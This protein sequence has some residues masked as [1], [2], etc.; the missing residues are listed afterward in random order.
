[1]KIV[2][3]EIQNSIILEAIKRCPEV[4]AVP[5]NDLDIAAAMLAHGEAD[6]MIAGID[7]TTRDVVVACRD[8]IGT[9]DKFFSSCFVMTRGDEKFIL[10]DGGVCKKP[11]ADMLTSVVL[12][13]YESAL[14]LLED[15]P[16]IAMLSFSTFGSGRD[17]SIDMIHEVINRVRTARPEILIDGE[18][19]LDV[20]INPE[21]AAKK[22]ANSPV[23]G[24][25][26]VL[27]CPDLN[28]GN[29]LYKALERLGGWTA[30]GPIL[31]GFNK[32]ISDLSRGSTVDD[33]VAVIK[34]IERLGA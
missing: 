25:A 1:M 8:N 22:A 27:V 15:T 5:T 29:I 24:V 4:T 31:Q 13:T 7:H 14:K 23:A 21:V 30:A 6:A 2:F 28:C 17:E 16:K 3:P 11:G 9:T 34:N 33:V 12:Q 20:A 26:N 18:M 19:Q 10:A 32:P